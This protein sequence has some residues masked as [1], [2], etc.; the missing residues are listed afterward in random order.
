[1]LQIFRAVFVFVV[2][3]Q[4]ALAQI[5]LSTSTAYTQNFDAMGTSGTATLPEN[6]RVDRPAT[7]RT[8]GTFAAASTATS[9]AGG[10]QP[11]HVGIQRHLQFRRRHD[12][13][14]AGPRGRIS[15]LGNRDPE[16]QPLRPTGQHHR[17]Q[18]DRLQISYNVEKYRG[19]SNAAGFRMQ[20]FYSIDGSNWT[21]AGA[22]FLTSFAADANNNGFAT[23]PGATS[24]SPTRPWR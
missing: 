24:P 10:R 12:Y 7:V 5:A 23:A 22:S 11:L 16:R 13:Y 19:G 14:R 6:F 8:V 18:P 17:R 2:C 21:S 20:M 4:A 15:F 9:L 3:Q 1:M